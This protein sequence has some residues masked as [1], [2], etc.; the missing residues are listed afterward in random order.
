[1]IQLSNLTNEKQ[2]PQNNSGA[3]DARDHFKNGASPKTQMSRKNYLNMKIFIGILLCAFSFSCS[4]PESD[5]KKTAK[6]VAKIGCECNR[7]NAKA[8]HKEISKFISEFHSSGFRTRYEAKRKIFALGVTSG[9]QFDKCL[10]NKDKDIYK[11][12]LEKYATNRQKETEFVYAYDQSFWDYYKACS[13][14]ENPS[15]SLKLQL[16]N[17]INTL[18]Q[19]RN[20]PFYFIGEVGGRNG[21]W[22][23]Y[24]ISF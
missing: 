5:G 7:E 19:P 21:A 23:T 9:E 20:D 2:Q 10:K 8:Y 18:P 11:K 15:S 17:L 22:P 6:K 3:M 16:D 1:M 24:I 4:N 13:A 14:T 12:A